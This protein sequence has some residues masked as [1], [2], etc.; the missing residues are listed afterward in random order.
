MNKPSESAKR[1]LFVDDDADTCDM[2]RF[3][4]E[5]SGYRV[6]TAETITDALRLAQTER[7]DLYLLDSW[8]P[9]GTGVEL[10]Q[11]LRAL[12]PASPILFY[13]GVAVESEIERAKA[14]GADQYLIKPCDIEQLQNVIVELIKKRDSDRR[15]RQSE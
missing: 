2:I 9:D 8:M 5:S 3:V 1:I 7:F 13:S 11:Q 12:S 14:A 15:K 4:L 6:T 10:C